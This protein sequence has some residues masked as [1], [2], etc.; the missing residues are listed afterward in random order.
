MN[1]YIHA[2]AHFVTNKAHHAQHNQCVRIGCQTVICI[3]LHGVVHIFSHPTKP[4]W[5]G[6]A[7]RPRMD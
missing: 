2:Q 6:T 1:T 4:V 3:L 5:R 7:S